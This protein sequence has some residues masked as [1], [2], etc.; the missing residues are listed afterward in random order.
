MFFQCLPG[1][2]WVCEGLVE[3]VVDEIASRLD[4]EYHPLGL[5]LTVVCYLL[6]VNVD[7]RCSLYAYLASVGPASVSS[8]KWSMQ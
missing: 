5:T 3:E 6:C 2:C 7:L 8:S 4:G 1:K